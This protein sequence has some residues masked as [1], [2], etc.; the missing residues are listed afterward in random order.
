VSCP[1]SGTGPPSY[2]IH[3]SPPNDRSMQQGHAPAFLHE[4]DVEDS[5]GDSNRPDVPLQHRRVALP[6]C[7]A[8]QRKSG[9]KG[10][11]RQHRFAPCRITARRKR[12]SCADNRRDD[13]RP[14]RR[15]DLQVEIK[16]DPRTEK[17]RQPQETPLA[18]ASKPITKHGKKP[19]GPP[20]N[21][22]KASACGRRIRH[23]CTVARA[24]RGSEGLVN[25]PVIIVARASGGSARNWT[26]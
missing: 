14:Q 22:T 16:T 6:G 11:E 5:A 21:R 20:Q 2:N 1:R 7:L 12:R 4:F 24:L 18:F 23:L 8:H 13:S 19:G 15:L 10:G 26:Q 3:S 17:H 9:G 25:F